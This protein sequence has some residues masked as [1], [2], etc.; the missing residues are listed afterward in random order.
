MLSIFFSRCN[1]L[2]VSRYR[3]CTRGTLLPA[4]PANRS[5]GT[6]AGTPA[7]GVG[8]ASEIKEPDE[9]AGFPAFE[10]IPHRFV[11]PDRLVV[12]RID[13]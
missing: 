5:D 11:Q 10:S 6:P 13:L 3:S 9:L 8:R 12:M 1:R 4:L 7:P 2:T